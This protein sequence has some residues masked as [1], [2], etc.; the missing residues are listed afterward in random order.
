M[1]TLTPIEIEISWS[2]KSGAVN[3]RIYKRQPNSYWSLIATVDAPTTSYIFNGYENTQY[4]F[5]VRVWNGSYESDL[6]LQN[7]PQDV[8][9]TWQTPSNTPSGL[10]M[11]TPYDIQYVTK[12]EFLTSPIAKGLGYTVDSIDYTD[13]TIDHA[14]LK[15]SSYVNRYCRRYFNKMTIDEIYPNV[16]IQVSNPRLTTVPLRYGPV[17]NINSI[18]IQVLKW[19]IPFTKDYLIQHPEQ[20]FYQIVPMISS[21]GTTGSP[22]PSVLL[23][24]SDLGIIWTNY[25]FGYDVIPEDIKHAVE[26]IAGQ[27]LAMLK[28]NPMGATSLK[29]GNFAITFGK[30]EENPVLNEVKSILNPW[31]LH[32]LRMT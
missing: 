17:Q 12:D 28:Q 6:A 10:P 9:A 22:I 24:Q 30:N 3:Y 29:T 15:A 20:R 11:V 32:T 13:G 14:L 16:T 7:Y 8:S 26:V 23:E 27:E 5:G 25:T 1:S 19:F 4:M 18:T 21:S 2:T 31:V